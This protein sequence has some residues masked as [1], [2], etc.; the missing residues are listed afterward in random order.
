[1]AADHD[2]MEEAVAAY[3]LDACDDDDER[4]RVRAHVAGCPGCRALLERLAPAVEAL[5]LA[6]DE[7]RPPD[8]LRARIL[9]A[10]A[11][12]RQ[13]PAGRDEPAP[14]IVPLPVR[15]GRP[16]AG[17]GRRRAVA[18]GAAAVAACALVALAG[19]NVALQRQL[20]AAPARFDMAGTGTLAGASGTVHGVARAGGSCR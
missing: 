20:D 2:R 8:L 15:G 6:A 1:M 3:A 17:R 16:V 12:Q 11:A 7:V 13:A 14:R 18:A 19:W 9:A 5:P 4:E 10:A